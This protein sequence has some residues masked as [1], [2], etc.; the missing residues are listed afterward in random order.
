METRPYE[1]KTRNWRSCGF[2]SDPLVEYDERGLIRPLFGLPNPSKEISRCASV[3]DQ[4]DALPDDGM[5][6]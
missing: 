3:P 4:G 1:V 6:C 5:G 2:P